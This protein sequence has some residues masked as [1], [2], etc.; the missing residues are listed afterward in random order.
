MEKDFD[1]NDGMNEDFSDEVLKFMSDFA[2]KNPQEIKLSEN[3]DRIMSEDR[4]L[5][6]KLA[7]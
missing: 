1:E 7:K 5:L 4:K 2:E 6:K 3:L